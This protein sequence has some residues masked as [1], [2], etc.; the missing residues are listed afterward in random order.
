M[1]NPSEFKLRALNRV[2]DFLLELGG[3]RELGTI[4]LCR[5]EEFSENMAESDL[6]SLERSSDFLREILQGGPSWVHVNISKSDEYS[7]L[8]I[9]R[10]KQ[11]GNPEPTINVS[12]NTEKV[13][14]DEWDAAR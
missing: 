3:S 4:W 11:V 5:E 8:S 9:C 14:I 13:S 6:I 10:G 1:E 12:L 7:I 2:S